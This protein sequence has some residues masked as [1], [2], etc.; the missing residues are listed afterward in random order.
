VNAK[1]GDAWGYPI[2]HNGRLY[3]RYYDTLW[4]YDVAKP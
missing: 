4:C 1:K 3:V 2:L